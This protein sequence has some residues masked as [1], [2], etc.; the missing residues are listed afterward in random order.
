[1]LL[2]ELHKQI[3]GA[4]EDALL[5]SVYLAPDVNRG[6]GIDVYVAGI[7]RADIFF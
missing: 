5:G 7:L 3:A 2:S 4:P 1:M 6:D